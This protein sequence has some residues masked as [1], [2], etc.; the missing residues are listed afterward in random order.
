MRS[1]TFLVLPLV[2]GLTCKAPSEV[3]PAPPVRVE[4]HQTSG[5]GE[6]AMLASA[7][8]E[9]DEIV[10]RFQDAS[11]PPPDHRS[12]TITVQG[13][14]ILRV[15]DSYG[16][17]IE[18]HE[19]RL[20]ERHFEEFVDLFTKAGVRNREQD[21]EK[22]A[23]CTGGTSESIRLSHRG[24]QVF[25]GRIE[26]CGGEDVANFTGDLRPLISALKSRVKGEP[27]PREV[28]Q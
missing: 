23:G 19:A 16:D 24:N 5:E 14:S 13:G 26:R 6:N 9:F 4:P 28:G 3:D 22:L 18:R 7:S 15:V 11:V 20:D 1:G 17:E 2:A 12:V 10:Y 25:A 8:S 27:G 21:D